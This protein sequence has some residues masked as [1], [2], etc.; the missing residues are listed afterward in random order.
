MFWLPISCGQTSVFKKKTWLPVIN[1]EF[2]D[3]SSTQGFR[4]F[5]LYLG[6][7]QQ[8]VVCSVVVLNI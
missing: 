1:I 4:A 7:N 3:T 5:N 6:E 2:L 8:R